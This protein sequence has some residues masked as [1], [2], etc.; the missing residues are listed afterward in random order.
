MN[1]Q[2]ESPH[3]IKNPLNFV[4]NFAEASQEL[5][6]ELLELAMANDNQPSEEELVE[7]RLIAG[8]LD[9]NLERI[10]KHG[11]RADRIVHDM[12]R[13]G[14]G[15]GQMQSIKFNELVD[16]HTRLAYHGARAAVDGFRMELKFELGED[17]GKIMAIP[18][19]LG[20]V[21]LNMVGNACYATHQKRQELEEAGYTD[22]FPELTVTTSRSGEKEVLVAIRDNGSGIPQELIEKIFNPFFT[23]KPTDEGTGLG[24]ALSNDIVQQHGGRIQVESSVGE[25]TEMRVYV[26]TDA[27][28]GLEAMEFGN[29]TM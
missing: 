14:R 3:E 23:T 8:E 29:A 25:Y 17:V 4:K 10:R 19:D 7:I 24:L 11:L 13:M 16:E 22:Y 9:E 28:D 21:V 27:T 6:E 20:R 12:L 26:P 5:V 15:V 18:Q 2:Q 1:S